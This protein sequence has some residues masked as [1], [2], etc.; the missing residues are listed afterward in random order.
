MDDLS[1]PLVEWL[2]DVEGVKYNLASSSVEAITLSELGALEE[3]LALGYPED[4]L[5]ERLEDK[6]A[7]TYEEDVGTVITAGAQAAN[8]LIVDALLDSEDEVLVEDPSYTP[9]QIGPELKGVDVKTFK[10]S[11]KDDFKIDLDGIKERCSSDTKMI[12]LTNP[13]NPSGVF[14]HPKDLREISEF[15]EEND[16]YLVIDE[17]YRDFVENGSSGVSI[18]DNVIVTSSLSKIYGLGGLRLG[19]AVSKDEELIEKLKS[20]K[21]YLSPKG[22]TPTLEIGLMAFEERGRLLERARETAEKGRSLARGWVSGNSSIEWVEPSS[23][24][25]SFPRLKME[26]DGEEFAKRAKKAGVLVAPGSYFS[27]GSEFDSHI[28]LTF[29][30]DFTSI[31]EGFQQLSKVVQ[32]I[33]DQIG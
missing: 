23:G 11:Y 30:K 28:R 26:I 15:I 2:S 4:E 9:L 31:V 1:F 5:E 6:I 7:N 13:H 21:S 10:R 3:H 19:W 24:I 8:S 16:I 20:V 33:N 22:P 32:S 25:I 14:Q 17:I 12:V 27:Q 18:S 29:G